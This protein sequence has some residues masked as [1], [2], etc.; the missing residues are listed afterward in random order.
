VAG[1][2]AVALR[3]LIGK[4]LEILHRVLSAPYLLACR[5]IVSAI[6]IVL[7]AVCYAE[8]FDL[9]QVAREDLD[10]GSAIYMSDGVINMA[11][12]NFAGAKGNDLKDPKNAV[13]ANH[14]GF[15]VEDIAE[16]QKNAGDVLFQS[17]ARRKDKP[18]GEY[19]WNWIR[20]L[21]ST[22]PA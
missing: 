15:Q 20:S 18:Y 13:G 22:P 1:K 14:F 6:W 10:I 8:V 21:R 2:V 9:E 5:A 17:E 12:L 19:F 11:L 3:D 4:R 16:T 7:L